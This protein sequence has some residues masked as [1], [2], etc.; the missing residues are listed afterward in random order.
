M[1]EL[2]VQQA[3]ENPTS[4]GTESPQIFFAKTVSL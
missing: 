1:E 4:V 2:S 3:L